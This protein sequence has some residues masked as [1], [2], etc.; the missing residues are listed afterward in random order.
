MI[1]EART[2]GTLLVATPCHCPGQWHYKIGVVISYNQL[3]GAEVLH[4]ITGGLEGLSQLHFQLKTAMVCS[5]TNTH[6]F[7]SA[8]GFFSIRVSF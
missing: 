7:F 6:H 3:M 2:P 8:L 5:Y 1:N 4:F